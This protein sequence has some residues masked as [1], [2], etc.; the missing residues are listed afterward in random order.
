MSHPKQQKV[1]DAIDALFSDTSVPPEATLEA[2]EEIQSE[3]ETKIDCLK[4]DI[5]RKEEE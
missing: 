1:L 4:A 5:A 3:I 2:L